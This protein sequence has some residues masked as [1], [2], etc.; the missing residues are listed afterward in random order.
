MFTFYPRVRSLIKLETPIIV[1]GKYD[2]IRLSNIIDAP[3]ITTDGFRIFK[4]TEKRRLIARIAREK[5]IIIITDS[6]S[7]GM[8]IRNHIKNF[9][10]DG[11]ITNVYLPQLLGK[12]K[13]KPKGSA[14]GILGVEGTA[15][16]IIISALERA[17]I[18][19]EKYRKPARQLTKADLYS[20]G[21]YGGENSTELR[22]RVLR[23]MDLP[24]NLS[25]NS[26]LEAV[27]L[28]FDFDDFLKRVQEWEQ[29]QFKN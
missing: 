28:L 7:A 14:E 3:I 8:L 10:K 4:D 23:F 6:D 9:V 21:L 13:R 16:E 25:V 11:S 18:T 19:G 12:E 1:E 20:L 22:K 15:D 26:F 24:D 17:G 5:G 29:A 27:N 2:K